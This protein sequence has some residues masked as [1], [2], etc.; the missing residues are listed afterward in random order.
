MMALSIAASYDLASAMEIANLAAGRV[1]EKW[2]TQ[3]IELR[4]LQEAISEVDLAALA[5]VS[6]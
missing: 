6:L 1:V 5:M 2:G 3:P 4:E